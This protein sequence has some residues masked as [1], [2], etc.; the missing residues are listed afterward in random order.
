VRLDG[1][2]IEGDGPAKGTLG[3]IEPFFFTV[4]QAEALVGF[5]KI[6]FEEGGL[7]KCLDRFVVAAKVFE[8]HSKVIMTFGSLGVQ[9]GCFLELLKGGFFVA[10]LK[11]DHPEKFEDVAVVGIGAEDLLVNFPGL[12]EPTRLVMAQGGLE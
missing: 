11:I 4:D 8:D 3:I 9:A 1:L 5:G 2:G 10:E 12:V 6:G 7:M